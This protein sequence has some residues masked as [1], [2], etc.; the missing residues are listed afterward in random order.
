VHAPRRT[1]TQTGAA[2]GNNASYSDGT[3]QAFARRERP[4]FLFAA[5]GVTPIALSNGVQYA[6]PPGVNCT[7]AGSPA[8]CDPIFTLV[9]PVRTE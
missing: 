2:Y 9:Q 8:P 7:I 3:W 1:L 6:A 4:H 5:D